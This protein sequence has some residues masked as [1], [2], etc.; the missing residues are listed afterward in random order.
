MP[1]LSK[2]LFLSPTWEYDQYGIATIT[3]MLVNDLHKTD[4]NGKYRLVK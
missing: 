1:V 4:P 2:P 3:K